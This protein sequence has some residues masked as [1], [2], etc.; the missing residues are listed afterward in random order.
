MER[1]ERYWNAIEPIWDSI[2]IDSVEA[3]QS[4]FGSVPP[5]LGFLYA[6]HFC[7]SE[8]CN[9]G[10]TQFFRNST[11]VLAPEAV[12][13]FLAIGQLKVA[14][15]VEKAISMLGSP[16]SRDRV[17]RWTILDRLA[18]SNSSGE[19]DSRS[20]PLEPLEREFYSLLRTEAGGFENA[21]DRYAAERGLG[22]ATPP[23]KTFEEAAKS[24]IG[25]LSKD[26]VKRM[27]N[28]LSDLKTDLAKTRRRIAEGAAGSS[29]AP[30]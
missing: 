4:T 10:F 6:A 16:Y 11:G 1:G 24:F 9:G 5:E 14:G 27:K 13:G 23:S 28:Q 7:Q 8:V 12:R 26:D 18:P 20:S 17:A 3:F 19:T 29:D 30:E 2:N 22:N 25:A 21:A 15:I